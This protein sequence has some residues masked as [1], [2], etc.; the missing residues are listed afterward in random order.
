[1]PFILFTSFWEGRGNV[2]L[3]VY[4]N[5]LYGFRTCIYAYVYDC[6]TLNLLVYGHILDLVSCNSH[7]PRTPFMIHVDMPFSM[8]MNTVSKHTNISFL[9]LLS[10]HLRTPTLPLQINKRG[11]RKDV[12]HIYL[13]IG[14]H[15]RCSYV[16]KPKEVWN[17]SDQSCCLQSCE[18]ARANISPDKGHRRLCISSLLRQRWHVLDKVCVCSI[19]LTIIP[20]LNNVISQWQARGSFGDQ[21]TEKTKKF[22]L[23]SEKP[24]VF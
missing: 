23:E 24:Y 6:R 5:V 7:E 22:R 17:V 15:E 20:R 21:K 16:W 13:L 9:V 4:G 3:Y 11:N 10:F 18:Q 1:M 8:P 19:C 12:D 14:N 2:V